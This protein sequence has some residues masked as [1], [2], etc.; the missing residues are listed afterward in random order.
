MQLRKYR[1]ELDRT[2]DSTAWKFKWATDKNK[3]VVPKERCAAFIYPTD[4][5]L[6]DEHV[7][8]AIKVLNL[9]APVLDLRE[10][11]RV[12]DE[13]DLIADVPVEQH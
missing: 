9:V 5:Q 4:Q 11:D 1:S 8:R 6:A 3:G 2:I 10:P 13:L 12:R 7:Q